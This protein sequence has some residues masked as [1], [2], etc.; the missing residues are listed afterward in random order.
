[1]KLT[2]AC[3]LLALCCVGCKTA[4]GPTP[5]QGVRF[6]NAE[7]T[8]TPVWGNAL[9]VTSPAAGPGMLDGAMSTGHVC[10]L[11]WKYVATTDIGDVYE[12]VIV[13]GWKGSEVTT[14]AKPGANE[15][16]I[17]RHVGYTGAAMVVYQDATMKI[18]M[19]P[20]PPQP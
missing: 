16:R 18:T 13:P 14:Q 10:T 9:P 1:V 6:K 17:I 19:E 20:A 8:I 4:Q 15:P 2:Y 5:G 12:F 7:I 11:W 3:C